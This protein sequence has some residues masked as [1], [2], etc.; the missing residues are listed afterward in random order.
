MRRKGVSGEVKTQ[1]AGYAL[2][3]DDVVA[4]N[5]VRSWGGGVLCE[6][7][8]LSEGN[9]NSSQQVIAAE[10]RVLQDCWPGLWE[11]KGTWWS[12]VPQQSA[13]VR[14]HP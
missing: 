4:R 13:C 11:T 6:R 1:D 7:D 5:V 10:L 3:S 14:V 12:C 2:Q 8:G 9:G